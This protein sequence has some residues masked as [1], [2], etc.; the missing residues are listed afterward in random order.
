MQHY[1]LS[2]LC[3]ELGGCNGTTTIGSG[4]PAKSIPYQ[5][6]TDSKWRRYPQALYKQLNLPEMVYEPNDII[7]RF[8]SEVKY[9]FEGDPLPLSA[10]Q[11]DLQFIILNQLVNG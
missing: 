3:E 4:G 11:Y 5:D 7:L 10:D 9:W 2:D 1:Q 6:P 8:N